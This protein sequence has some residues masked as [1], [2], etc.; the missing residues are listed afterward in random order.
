MALYADK[1]FLIQ[2]TPGC[3]GKGVFLLDLKAF[4]SQF[5]SLQFSNAV[6]TI[7]RLES[8]LLLIG[9]ESGQV[10]AYEFDQGRLDFRSSLDLRLATG[11]TGSEDIEIRALWVDDHDELVFAASS[12]GNDQSRRPE[13]PSLFVLEMLHTPS[14]PSNLTVT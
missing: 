10:H 6:R 4:S 3:C 12:W 2:T 14:A 8:E 1:M 11:H 7:T 9:T 5:L 13:L